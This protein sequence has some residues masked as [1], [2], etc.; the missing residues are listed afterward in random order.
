MDNRGRMS[1]G[2]VTLPAMSFSNPEPPLRAADDLESLWRWLLDGPDGA[3]YS[4]RTLWL[5]P[6]DAADRPVRVVVPLDGVPDELDADDVES[7]ERVIADLVAETSAECVPMMLS[8]PGDAAMTDDDRRFALT[9]RR[10]FGPRMGRWP[11]HLATRHRIQV[12]APDDLISV[13]SK[14]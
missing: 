2:R 5:M 13:P 9:L 12:F 4:C 8:R 6:L 10:E 11:I 1:A 7:L 3:D 14:S